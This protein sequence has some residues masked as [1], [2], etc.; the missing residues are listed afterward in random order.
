MFRTEVLLLIDFEKIFQ[1]EFPFEMDGDIGQIRVL[2]GYQA[3]G[4]QWW[5]PFCQILPSWYNIGH[6]NQ[7]W[8]MHDKIYWFS[9]YGG[10]QVWG[11]Q[12][13]V[14]LKYK[15]LLLRYWHT[16]QEKKI[17]DKIDWFWV[18][19][20]FQG[21]GI[22]WWCLFC[23][24]RIMIRYWIFLPILWN[25]IKGPKFEY[26]G[27][28]R[29]K[30]FNEKRGILIKWLFLGEMLGNTVKFSL[31]WGFHWRGYQNLIPFLALM[32][33]FN[34]KIPITGVGILIKWLFF[35][36]MVGNTVKF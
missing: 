29:C 31:L 18:S 2:G 17:N 12:W 8:E 25:M 10:F 20:C 30:E 23:H 15:T 16:Y 35:G 4:I 33:R 21:R 9:A 7:D 34:K 26:P 13:H 36:K 27:V 24:K 14:L 11:I 19:M 22:Q 3:W 6:P 1:I 5:C 28:Y 32:D